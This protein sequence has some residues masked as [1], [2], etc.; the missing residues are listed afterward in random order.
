[1]QK[2]LTIEEKDA[3]IAE[4][5]AKV[6]SLESEL[7]YLRKKVF[8]K[9]S[10]KNLPSDPMQEPTLF[11]NEMTISEALAIDVQKAKDE[12]IITRTIT[13]KAG[14]DNRKALDTT[15]LPVEEEHL[16]PENITEEYVEIAP[17]VTDTL[18]IQPAKMYIKRIVRHKFVL[19]SSLQIKEPEKQTFK[20]APLP[21]APIHKC[22]ASSSILADIII[23]KFFYHMPFYRVIQKYKELGVSIS[24]STMGDWYAAACEKLKILYDKLKDDVF[25]SD[26]IQ[27]D[28]STLPVIDNEKH[29]AVK[30]YMWVV[31]NANTGDAIYHYDF[32]SRS[33]E[34][35]L[36]LLKDF[37]GAIQTDGYQAYDRFE[38]MKGKKML[39]CWAHTRRKFF[40]ALSE[41]KKLAEEGIAFIGK[42]YQI[43]NETRELSDEERAVRR[44]RESYQIILDFEVWLQDTSTKV[45][46][47]GRMFKAI[48]YAYGLLPRLSRYVQNGKYNIDN[49]LIE[50]VIRPL[51][52]GRKNYLFCGNADAAIR[53]GIIYSLITSCKAAEVEPRI[54][55][56]DVL[57][58]LPLYESSGKDVSELLP[59]NWNK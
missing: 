55:L 31:R 18:A 14:K 47:N 23:E 25:N 19:K 15:K 37:N 17:E 58:K 56:E 44:Q 1:M 46:K 30:G 35:A 28:E 38:G 29:R 21:L 32:G 54:W 26:Y 27:V 6:A 42:L 43:E 48:Q 8:G 45:I 16:Y 52:I 10:E 36:K 11:D 50:N 49:N 53:A 4:L 51:A 22:M 34:T 7:Y 3:R 59:R 20:I 41:N 33:T 2:A 39:G 40:D 5:E 24:S 13:V 9:M 12:E 57:G